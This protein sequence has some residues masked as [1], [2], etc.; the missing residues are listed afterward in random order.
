M[1]PRINKAVQDQLITARTALYIDEPFFGIMALRL[2]MQESK[3]VRT[4]C[5]NYTTIFYNP[6]WIATL[7]KPETVFL[8]GHECLH[9]ML[10]HLDRTDDRNR[11][12][13]NAACDYVINLILVEQGQRSNPPTMTMPKGGLYD[14]AYRNMSAEHVYTLLPDEPTDGKGGWGAMDD[15]G[16]AGPG[17]PE[18]TDEERYVQ[19]RDWLL[20]AQ[21]AAKA[22]KEQGCL[23]AQLERF[24]EVATTSKGAWK[25]RLRRFAVERSR[26]DNSWRHPQRR[27]IPYGLFLPS[28]YSEAMGKLVFITDT[29]GSIDQYILNAFGAEIL[30]ARN[31]ARPK[32][33]VNIFCDAAVHH[34]NEFG[35]YDAVHFRLPKG[36]GGGTDFR[37]AFKYI[38]DHDI[39]PACVVYLTDGCG[40]YP[41]TAPSYPVLWCMTTGRIPPW[42]EHMRIDV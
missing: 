33:L 38:E 26:A 9:P 4:A 19:K 5:V 10:G 24:V 42:G 6:E 31:A 11:K 18:L 41:S 2:V 14:I 29:S 25:Q 1:A 20:T 35:E 15:M 8:V 32:S 37:P 3:A 17:E 16:E 21:G 22:A 7:N 30:A 23:P 39:K 34:V 13:W 27:M 36:G 28:L 40:Y 12:R